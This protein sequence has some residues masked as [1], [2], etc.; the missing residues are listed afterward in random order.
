MQYTTLLL[1]GLCVAATA[2]TA[3]DADDATVEPGPTYEVP[4][5][6]AFED[7]DY[8]GQQSRIAQL[9]ELRTYMA[10]GGTGATLDAARLQAMYVNGPG[11]GYTNA[12][13]KDMRS[14]V[15]EPVRADFDR[16]F[17]LL[18][19]ASR[20]AGPAAVGQAG[21]LTSPD[22]K[23]AYLVNARGVEYAQLIQKGLM[24]ALLYYQAT[25]VYMG[26]E[27]M[28]ADNT[29]VVPGQGTA[30]QHH[31]DEAFGYFGVPRDFPANK[32]GA[33]FWG[34][35]SDERDAAIGSNE[36]LMGALIKGRAAILNDDF[37]ARDAAIAEA[38]TVWELIAA[39]SVIHYLNVARA[40]PD[41][42]ALRMHVL[43]EGIGFAYAL[44]FNEATKMP[45]DDY[46]AWVTAL[47]GAAEFEAMDFYG[48]DAAKMDI[49]RRAIAERYGLT[50]MLDQL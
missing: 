19:A 7:V 18:A 40:N 21:V 13:P 30:M 23:R 48:I 5:T 6:Y 50:A 46:R 49:A 29:T 9:S 34:S 47:A 42:A 26:A 22:G 43:S 1:A 33:V 11:A 8:A 44:Q 24:G 10:T 37:A 32:V 39:T 4:T 2:F 25:T 16:Y 3:C 27:K 45:R 17:D 35:Y 31:W 38:R 28:A 15:F 20:S 14:K 36:R 41:N 12:Y